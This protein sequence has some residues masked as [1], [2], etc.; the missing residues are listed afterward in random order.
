MEFGLC[1]GH[2]E[3]AMLHE[4]IQKRDSENAQLKK[5]VKELKRKLKLEKEDS[6]SSEEQVNPMTSGNPI[7]W[8]YTQ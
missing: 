7:N 8:T 4:Q 1:E 3:I 2:V 6:P 5:T